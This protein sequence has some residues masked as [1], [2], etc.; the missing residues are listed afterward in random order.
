LILINLPAPHLRQPDAQVPLGLLYVAAAVEGCQIKDYAT[1]SMDEA[2]ADLPRDEFYGITCT[3]LQLPRANEFAGMIKAKYNYSNIILGGPGT[4]TPEYVDWGSVDSILQGEGEL[5]IGDAI[6]EKLSKRIYKGHTVDVNKC[7]LPARHL[8]ENQGGNIFSKNQNYFEGGSAQIIT[9]R[10]CSFNCAFC[11][12]PQNG[13]KV[14][15]RDIENVVTEIKQVIEQYGIRQFRIADDNFTTSKQRV[16]DFCKQVAP[17][18]I[19]FRISARVKPFDVEM[20]RALKAA[21]CKEI[22]FGVESFDDKV[23]KRLRK[24]TTARDNCIALAVCHSVGIKTRALLMIGTPYQ[25]LETIISNMI[26]TTDIHIDTIACTHFMPLP[27]SDVYNNPERYGIE[28]VSR[29]LAKYNFYSFDRTGQTEFQDIF[30]I[31]GRD[32]NEVR[33]ENADFM[34]YLK[35]TGK[36]NEG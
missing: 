4:V 25:T 29:D 28:I 32:A 23:L 19:A 33:A 26:F 10:G 34:E 30:T 21:G 17:L 3:S 6:K 13:S 18:G 7:P 36:L 1:Y 16:I 12:A 8:V 24:N 27:G 31:N 35:S 9:S 2:I 11:A 15:Y 22:S 20:A 5:V 14:R